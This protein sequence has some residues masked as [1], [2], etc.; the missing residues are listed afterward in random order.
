M[1]YQFSKSAKNALESADKLAR[2]L[3]KSYIG[4]EHLLYGLSSEENSLACKVLKKQNIN[5]ELIL[6]KIYNIS[7]KNNGSINKIQGFT[8]KTKRIIEDAYIQSEKVYLKS[9]GTEQ[10]LLALLNEK[11]NMAINILLDLKL[12]IKVAYH[13]IDKILE[14]EAYLNKMKKNENSN[15][16]NS[17]S[18]SAL[19]QYSTDL[20]KLAMEEKIDSVIGRNKEI[21][22]VIQILSRR[23]KNNP[24]LIGEPGVGKTAIAQGL[25]KK[26]IEKDVPENLQ[27]K[28]IFSLDLASVVAG[29]KYRGDF[30]DRIK[31][32]LAEIKKSKDII[33]FIDEIH[34]IVGA[35]AA[36]GAIDAANIL[37]PILARGEIQLIGATTIE[38][39]RKYIEKDAALERRFSPITVEEPDTKQTIE[40]LN[41]LKNKYEEHHHVLINEEVTEECVH[42]SKRYITDRCMPDKAID[43]LDE[44]ASKVK[45]KMYTLP[46]NIKE[47]E[48]KLNKT[49][50]EKDKAIFVQDFEKAAELRDE[51]VEAK[52]RL[53]EE[54]EKWRN[55][56]LENKV[57][58]SVDDIREVV[59]NLTGIPLTKI[60]Q[61]EN[62]KLNNLEDELKREIIGQENA[63]KSISSAIK[64]GRIGINDPNKPICSFLFLGSTG[65]GKTKLSKVLAKSLFGNESDI[66]KLD[67][68][69]Y[70]EAHSVSKIIGS[71]P[72]YIGYDEGGQLTKQIRQK[73]YSII[74]IDEIEKAHPDVI[75]ILLQ[76]L[77]EGNLT[78]SSGRK[79]NFKNTIIIMT[80]NI[81][82]ELITENKKIGFASQNLQE[83]N[84]NKDILNVLKR[85]FRPE[86][87]NRIDEII[88]FNKLSIA[89]IIKIISIEISKLEKRLEK[90]N[91]KIE[92]DENVKENIARNH[93][94]LNF[95]A[96]EIRRKIQQLIENV[97]AEKIVNEELKE[98]Q[99]IKFKLEENKICTI[100][101]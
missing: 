101:Q 70:M 80:S 45:L 13:D 53:E 17:N 67:M 2:T 25:A 4:T 9:I 64:R 1:I 49:I 96:R 11:E 21:E 50:K 76:I 39:Y 5:K 15:K 79:V 3:G 59:V 77:D 78:D 40:I 31:K 56:N 55:K 30:E 18:N 74:L 88:I 60:T 66:I 75:N 81:G 71:P 20:T 57:I 27:G 62:S 24:C 68:S 84:K 10:L 93:I 54:K 7:G 38:E 42:L 37:K 69:E 26:I 41:G 92:I 14:Q 97:I 46:E 82:S 48:E 95:G 65:V 34:N 22:R 52:N 90:K 6:N 100:I 33:L 73:P 23:T 99:L 44:A 29:A 51:E 43:L 28:R 47:L 19:Y 36:E 58:L 8:Q 85:Q 94:D 35:G 86:F 72:G 61:T 63:I 83:E 12:D 91:I 87:L 98:N 16:N 32:C 89:D